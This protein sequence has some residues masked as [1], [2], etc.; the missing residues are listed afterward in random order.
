MP[1]DSL[2]GPRL[3]LSGFQPFGRWSEN[4]S[5]WA[6]R[7]AQSASG[8]LIQSLEL[9]VEFDRAAA[10]LL[11]SFWR[12]RPLEI[13]ALGMAA[14]RREVSVETLAFN[15]DR[16][17]LPDNAGILRPAGAPIDAEGPSSLSP[18]FPREELVDFLRRRGF[19]AN[20]SADAGRYVCNN[21]FY[22]AARALMPAGASFTFVHAPGPAEW[23][24]A[25]AERFGESLAAWAARPR[26]GGVGRAGLEP[27]TLA[28]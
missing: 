6:L 11:E 9:P 14:G 3:L 22:L 13:I 20:L 8:G 21:L 26:D 1:S 10:L 12:A 15:E 18:P 5:L 28:L 27:A 24:R 2:P 4:T 19:E 7:A 25:E 16:A 23:T 17:D